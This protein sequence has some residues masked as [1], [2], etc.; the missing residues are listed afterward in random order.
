MKNSQL[1]TRSNL[2]APGA[3]GAQ[4][5]WSRS[6]KDGIGTAYHTGCRL[7][8]T[9]SQGVVSEIYCPT[10]DTPN[11]RELHFLITD[12]ESFC[13]EE[14]RD[15]QRAV[16]MPERGALLYRLTNSEATGRYR[17]IK[18]VLAD[19]HSSVLLMRTRLEI[20]DESLRG[21]L[22]LFALLSPHLGGRGAENTAQWLDLGGRTLLHAERE[23][24]HLVFGSDRGFSRRSVGY[25]GTSDGWQDL[26]K[27]NFQMDWQ[28]REAGPGSL[29]LTGEVDLAGT[30]DSAISASLVDGG[31][32][33]EFVLGVAFGDSSVSA[34]AKLVQSFATPFEKHRSVY[35][36]QWQRAAAESE[37]EQNIMEHTGDG[38]S[39]YRLS[40][41]VLLAHE[42]KNFQGALI[43]SLST[44]WGE[45]KTDE[46]A[47]GYHLVWTRDLV[48]SVSALVAAGDI[49]TP[50]RAL[51]WLT[52][53]Q[54]PDG[55]FPQNSWIDGVPYWQGIQLDEMAAPLL[56]GWRL[57][58]AA[59][60]DFERARF[61][62][63]LMGAC[64]YL[65]TAG[66]VTAQERWE[67]NAGYSPSTLATIIAALCAGADLSRA[68]G[69]IERADFT[70]AYADWLN[71]HVEDWCV[72]T[73]G[74]RLPGKPRHYVRITPTDPLAP[75]PHP[76]PNMLEVS[77]AG[78]SD[79]HPARE[80]VGGDF[81]HLVRLGVRPADDPIVLDSVEV[82]DAL[83]KCDLPGG[84]CWRRY[85]FDVY[86]Q[87][88]DGNA[89]DGTGEGRSWPILTGE[90]GHY[91]V[92]AGR[93]PLPFIQAMERF[94]SE[95]GLL[96]EQL[97]DAGDIP[98]KAMFYGRP[99]GSAMPLCWSHAEYLSLVRSSRDGQ[100]FDRIEPAFQRYV[101]EGKR[102]ST[103][104][105]WTFRHR[106]R[107]VP[108][109]RTLR[110]IVQTSATVHWT[111]DSWVNT[112]K[113][114]TVAAGLGD[115]HFFDLPTA[116]LP[117]GRHAEWTFFWPAANR[118][119]GGEN[120]GAEIV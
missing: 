26:H 88:P 81:L 35:V 23:D 68:Y 19:P 119:E 90:R 21:K 66:P 4:A 63:V 102:Y 75:D 11:T 118:W 80:I 61:R 89:Y 31:N 28:H 77:L 107:R 33:V 120:F 10:V 78:N 109:G 84:P 114:D 62:P 37:D 86:G 59:P 50:M 70:L 1:A 56:L 43:A 96:P 71:S 5:F 17:L 72:T 15:L 108:A 58:R 32:G 113:S 73:T 76:D 47:G 97:W 83:L 46:D 24:F 52:C 30:G 36:S 100:V 91:E 55:S 74:Q 16:E 51:L 42:D 115:L 7:W 8:F 41:R 29:V 22:R 27:G 105:M 9:L 34:A 20:A 116:E 106:T 99:S 104:E 12:G 92:A 14:K 95:T 69:H 101:V 3:P 65:I 54:K 110:L 94:A 60:E 6:S 117:A 93:D 25:L 112:G 67:E 38:G 103:Y 57:W 111:T 82:Y 18:E 39:L 13:H 79:R 40:H 2:A 49:A 45:T 98:E 87:K 44:P 64:G 48:Q 85:P 53:I